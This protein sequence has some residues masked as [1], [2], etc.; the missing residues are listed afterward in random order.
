[1]TDASPKPV[2]PHRIA[3][4]QSRLRSQLVPWV[5]RGFI[6][7]F[8]LLRNNV[9]LMDELIEER[10]L[11]YDSKFQE[12]IATMEK[13]EAAF[14]ADF[15]LEETTF[16]EMLPQ[17]QWRSQY[18][19]I[20]ATFEHALNQVC[21]VALQR[22][23]LHSDQSQKRSSVLERTKIC[24]KKCSVQVDWGKAGWQRIGIHAKL[25]NKLVHANGVFTASDPEKT[26]IAKLPGVQLK[27]ED[28]EIT[29]LLG[30]ETL[31]DA[32]NVMHDSLL[33][34]ANYEHP[35]LA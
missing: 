15:M 5:Y 16:I 21:A 8:A 33:S 6:E 12:A 27:A 31:L 3:K 22:L 28:D 14:Y 23:E 18:L 17:L 35:D 32:I 34:L 7:D 4:L 24:L 9:T 19:M 13:D 10:R 26:L 30:T 11:Q 1:M 29:V 2:V 20:Y 25:R